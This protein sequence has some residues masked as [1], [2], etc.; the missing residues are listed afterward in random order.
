MPASD[1]PTE[2]LDEEV[3][4]AF[5]EDTGQTPEEIKARL[6]SIPMPDPEDLER[7]PAEEFYDGD[8]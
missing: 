5:A 2:L 3:L 6:R 7:I 8:S 4:A 1:D